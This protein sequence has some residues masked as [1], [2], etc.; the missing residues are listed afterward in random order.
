LE[1]SKDVGEGRGGEDQRKKE[2]E[3]EV[4]ETEFASVQF[5]GKRKSKEE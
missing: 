4:H 2:A 3:E 1:V 5:S